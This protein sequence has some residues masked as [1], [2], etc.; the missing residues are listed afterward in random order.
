[1]YKFEANSTIFYL[2]IG[3]DKGNLSNL[4]HI[5]CMFECRATTLGS[6]ILN[7]FTPLKQVRTAA[8]LRFVFT[9]SLAHSFLPSTDILG[10]HLCA[11]SWHSVYL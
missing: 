4:G 3:G 6:H 8:S 9:H 1:M 7:V 11:R 5:S 2:N 10:G